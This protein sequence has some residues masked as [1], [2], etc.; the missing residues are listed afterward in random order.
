MK[1]CSQVHSNCN[2]FQC[3][4][5]YAHTPLYPHLQNNTMYRSG[6]LSVESLVIMCVCRYSYVCVCAT[7]CVC[8]R[9]CELF[10]HMLVFVCLSGCV[11]LSADRCVSP[12]HSSC[13][14]CR[15]AGGDETLMKDAGWLS[16]SPSHFLCARSLEGVLEKSYVGQRQPAANSPY[17]RCL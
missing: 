8:T 13:Q 7:D 9:M 14:R 4:H 12:H 15:R 1:L 5:T 16:L 3:K 17:Y 6:Q 11:R 2:C 10:T